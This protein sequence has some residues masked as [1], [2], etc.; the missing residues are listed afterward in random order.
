MRRT[1]TLDFLFVAM[2]MTPRVADR[3]RCRRAAP[4]PPFD[5]VRGIVTVAVVASYFF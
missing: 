2:A 1:C 5:N 3:S 4:L